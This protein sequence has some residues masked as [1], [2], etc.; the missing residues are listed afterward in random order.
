MFSHIQPPTSIRNR[1][2]QPFFFR[3]AI[4][5]ALLASAGAATA[6]TYLVTNLNDAGAGSLREA[7]SKA[8]GHRG[9]DTVAFQVDGTITLASTLPAITDPS[10]LIIDGSSNH[11]IVSGDNAVQV[12]L[13]NSRAKLELNNLTITDG[14]FNPPVAVDDF[15]GIGNNGTL[16]IHNS[17]I[18]RN[19]GLPG[20]GGI[21][22]TGYLSIV[23]STLSNNTS[24]GTVGGILND[25]TLSISRSTLSA[26][27]GYGAGGIDNRGSLVI[28]G[29]TVFGN[30]AAQGVG[31]I[32]NKGKL[33]ISR[34]TI[35]NN[36]AR[37]SN[38]GIGGVFNEAGGIA[39]VGNSTFVGNGPVA[40]ANTTSSTFSIANTT[41][42]DNQG[43]SF[44][45]TALA[46]GGITNGGKLHIA[47]SIIANNTVGDCAT[48][49]TLKSSGVNW[50]GDGSCGFP[51]SGDPLLGPLADN[52]GP[53]ETMAPQAGSGAIDAGDDRVCRASPVKGVDQRGVKRPQ[54]SHC[55]IGA[56]E[57]TV[58]EFAGFSAPIGNLPLLNE[59]EAGQTVPLSFGLGAGQRSAS[60]VAPYPVSK[61]IDCSTDQIVDPSAV[62]SEGKLKTSRTVSTFHW[63]TDPAWSG[64]CR[65]FQLLYSDGRFGLVNFRFD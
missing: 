8:N 32:R 34:S 52:G 44:G 53:T 29:S 54:G 13:V 15:G 63:Q 43:N 19:N 38:L 62:P 10:G 49:G 9:R 17:R 14:R 46:P 37:A 18:L 41:I 23:D 22:N 64:T 39:E 20:A 28:D 7:I 60:F 12:M 50:V 57:T 40:I 25:G 42:V 2:G 35:T 51:A 59:I 16:I 48:T 1:V 33:A 26:N 30:S 58:N 21:K 3:T 31:G 24:G 4:A 27:A 61:E 55:D 56:F 65:Q 6:S 47:N 5:G 36:T 45:N 11:I